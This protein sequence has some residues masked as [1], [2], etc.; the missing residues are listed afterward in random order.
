MKLYIVSGTS[1]SGKSIALH[2]LEDLGY[3]CID[4]LPVGLLPAFVQELL[5][6]EREGYSNAAVG[7]DARNLA[8]DFAILP[9]ALQQ[10]RD[11]GIPYQI[12]FLD[13]DDDTLLKRFSE[14]R[15][16]HP[17]TR[18]DTPLADAIQHE[19]TLLEPIASRAD[20]RL[21]TSHTNVHQLRD[22][23]QAHVGASA[24]GKLSLLFESFGYKHGIPVDADFVFDIRCLP[25]PHWQPSL[26]AFTGRDPHVIEFLEQ[27]PEVEQ[28]FQSISGFLATWLPQFETIG[29]SYLTVAIGCTGGQHRSVYFAER[30]ARHFSGHVTGKIKVSVRHRELS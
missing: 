28:M 9:G 16:R 14:T 2:A 8:N 15:R 20:L 26:R 7:V 18:G 27:H 24:S 30:L 6:A 5:S 17:L 21:D 22:L 4:N 23:V 29:R 3:Y 10:L 12:L 11:S 19:R 13:A 1:G 25:N